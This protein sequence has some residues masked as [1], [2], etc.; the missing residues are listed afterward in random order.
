MPHS[1]IEKRVR[2]RARKLRKS[3]TRGEKAMQEYLR[4]LRPIGARFRRETPIGPYVVDYAWLSARIVVEVNGASHRLP[5]RAGEDAR[6]DDFLRSQ[7]FTV[8][9]VNDADAIA[10]A[11]TTFA[12][13]EDAVRPLLRRPS[14]NPSPQGGGELRCSAPQGRGDVSL[15]E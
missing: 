8:I 10:N 7:G 9:R 15:D 4:S 1:N 2:S 3:R 6:R 11:E 13:V 5:G 14:P 12:P